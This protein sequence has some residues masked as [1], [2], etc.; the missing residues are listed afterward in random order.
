MCVCVCIGIGS[1][2]WLLV[3]SLSVCQPVVPWEHGKDKGSFQKGMTSVCC[4]K[5]ASVFLPSV[6]YFH[7]KGIG[8]RGRWSNGTQG[9]GVE[10]TALVG[11]VV[12]ARF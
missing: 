11:N 10:D 5:D 2:V 3:C 7:F 9:D 4:F 1:I 8:G 12:P 6:R